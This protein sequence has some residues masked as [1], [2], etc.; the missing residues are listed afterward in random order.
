MV[1]AFW[2]D[3]SRCPVGSSGFPV[4]W[5]GPFLSG[6]GAPKRVVAAVANGVACGWCPKGDSK[7]Q[8]PMV[9]VP[10]GDGWKLKRAFLVKAMVY[11]WLGQRR[12]MHARGVVRR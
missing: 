5:C 12:V 4:G 2:V 10:P 6:E 7:R 1:W 3:A 11:V 9:F 8:K